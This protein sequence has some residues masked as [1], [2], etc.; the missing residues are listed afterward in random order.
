MTTYAVV[1]DDVR[2]AYGTTERST[3]STSRSRRHHAGRPRP[4]RRRQ[5]HPH[6]GP[7]HPIRPDRGRVLVDG[8]D[9]VADPSQV[10]RRIGVTGQ[11]AGLD[12]FL[13][14]TREPGA[15]RPARR[16]GR[17]RPWP[18]QRPGRAFRPARR[19]RPAGRGAV[20]R[21]PPPGRPGRQPGRPHRRCSS[22]TSPP[23]GSTRPPA[24]VWDVVTELTAAGTTVVLTTQYLEEAD[25]LADQSWSSTTAASPAGAPPPS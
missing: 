4:Q 6:P 22:S 7:D 3:A 5:D 19:R 13:T 9:V 11:Y 2:L 14:T 21:F 25:R 12:D 16:A 24:P 17:R 18:C 15:G 8:I 20:R 10:R 23:P 1:V